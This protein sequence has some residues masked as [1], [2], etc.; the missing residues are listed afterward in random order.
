LNKNRILTRK[1][2][3]EKPKKEKRSEM[4]TWRSTAPLLAPVT[5]PANP[6][7]SSSQRRQVA[8]T[9]QSLMASGHTPTHAPWLFADVWAREGKHNTLSCGPR[10][11]TVRVHRSQV[12]RRPLNDGI[13]GSVTRIMYTC[14]RV[15]PLAGGFGTSALSPSHNELHRI[16][17]DMGAARAALCR[18]SQAQGYICWAPL[19][20][21]I[22]HCRAPSRW[23]TPIP[24][25]PR[26]DRKREIMLPP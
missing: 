18:D 24:K 16:A 4:K 26:E 13:P 11:S 8:P 19:P 9:Y 25:H 12:L 17:M 15:V 14:T 22:D 7:P 20:P 21:V 10:R 1:R 6:C 2:K 23:A 3:T 5:H